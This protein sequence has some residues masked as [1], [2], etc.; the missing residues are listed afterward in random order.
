MKTKDS[1]GFVK[2][3]RLNKEKE[4]C[5]LDEEV[6][7]F[8]KVLSLNNQNT[9]TTKNKSLPTIESAK[10]SPVAK[11]KCGL[12]ENIKDDF[13]L[14][15]KARKG[16]LYIL[17]KMSNGKSCPEIKNYFKEMKSPVHETLR[18][19]RISNFNLNEY[20]GRK[21][22]IKKMESKTRINMESLNGDKKE[23]I[24]MNVFQLS[25]NNNVFNKEINPHKIKFDKNEPREK[26]TQYYNEKIYILKQFQEEYSLHELCLFYPEEIVESVLHKFQKLHKK[27]KKTKRKTQIFN[28]LEAGSS[29]DSCS[30]LNRTD[31][32]D[33]N[34]RKSILKPLQ[35]P[36]EKKVK[37]INNKSPTSKFDLNSKSKFG[38]GC[39]KLEVLEYDKTK[40][41][42]NS[43]KNLKYSNGKL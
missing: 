15:N 24:S 2:V 28:K 35:E 25:N 27:K 20:E 38:A 12:T 30:K 13:E 10:A 8:L 4:K 17:N 11:K 34:V 18:E 36:N 1:Y 26:N 37:F 43:N 19:K 41:L 39:I 42:N 40:A 22:L 6:F 32:I 16:L 3:L 23:K 31:E 9:K 14:K 33:K 21:S 29:N 5:Q 7:N